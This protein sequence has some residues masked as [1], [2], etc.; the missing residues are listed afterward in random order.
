MTGDSYVS[1]SLTVEEFR[2]APWNKDEREDILNSINEGVLDYF[3]E[4]LGAYKTLVHIGVPVEYTP[5]Y[6]GFKLNTD[7]SISWGEPEEIPDYLSG[8]KVE[9]VL[10]HEDVHAY[11]RFYGNCSGVVENEVFAHLVTLHFEGGIEDDKEIRNLRNGLEPEGGCWDRFVKHDAIRIS[12]DLNYLLEIVKE[13]DLDETKMIGE[14]LV[15]QKELYQEVLSNR[16]TVERARDILNPFEAG[17][18]S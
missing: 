9:T 1:S 11:Q 18:I 8:L 13:S 2:E 16:S 17:Q 7:R 10:A 15:N 14:A 3:T 12:R 4:E 5:E 6:N